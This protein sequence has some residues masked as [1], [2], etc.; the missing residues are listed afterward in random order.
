[1]GVNVKGNAPRVIGWPYEAR[2]KV[3]LGIARGRPHFQIA[4]GSTGHHTFPNRR[5]QYRA[6]ARQSGLVG[7]AGPKKEPQILGTP[8]SGA[9]Q[10]NR[11]SDETDFT[12]RGLGIIG[13]AIA[14]LLAVEG[15]IRELKNARVRLEA[16]WAEQKC[17]RY[18]GSR[19]IE[20]QSVATWLNEL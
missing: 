15:W 6:G 11:Q 9:K 5:E 16:G 4:Q 20:E 17:P 8:G 18:F 3:P 19:D 12:R 13:Q 14:L 1:M 7:P 2:W 10:F